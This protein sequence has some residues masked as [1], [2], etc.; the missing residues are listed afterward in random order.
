V[1][2]QIEFNPKVVKGY[3]LIGY[4][5]RLLRN[6]DFA[7]DKIDAGELGEGHQVT[8]LYEIIPAG[9]SESIR[10]TEDLRYQ[11]EKTKKVKRTSAAAELMFVKLRYKEPDGA[12]STLVTI[13]VANHP[14]TLENSSE[15]FRWASSV[16]CFGMILRES[17][18]TNGADYDLVLELAQGA[19][20]NDP[21]GYRQEF[22]D[23]VEKAKSVTLNAEGK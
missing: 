23:M 7:N 5:N 20:G 2:F 12:K 13:P 11:E 8:A 16:A 21:D 19:T 18:F 14:V 22:I 15:N 6:E 17:Q 10:G 4:E 3:R 1:K 9:S